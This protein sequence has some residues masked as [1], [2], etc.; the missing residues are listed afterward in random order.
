MQAVK[1]KPKNIFA[2][3]ADLFN[4]KKQKKMKKMVFSFNISVVELSM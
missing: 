4:I 1:E 3:A 2:F